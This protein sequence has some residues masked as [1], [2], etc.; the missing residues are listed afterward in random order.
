MSEDDRKAQRDA[1]QAILDEEMMK[2]RERVKAWQA[3]KAKK[4]A[5]EEAEVDH[6]S[7][8]EQMDEDQLLQ[9]NEQEGKKISVESWT[10]DDDEDDDTGVADGDMESETVEEPSGLDALP[11]LTPL[12]D[13]SASLKEEVQVANADD[14]A[15]FSISMSGQNRSAKRHPTIAVS[16]G[17]NSNTSTSTA[18]KPVVPFATPLSISKTQAH[19]AA[20]KHVPSPNIKAPVASVPAAGKR[21]RFAVAKDAQ[22]PSVTDSEQPAME[23]VNTDTSEDFDPLDAYMSDLY[24]GGDVTQQDTTSIALGPSKKKK[25]HVPPNEGNTVSVDDDSDDSDVNP[26]GSNF[27]TLDQIMGQGVLDQVKTSKPISKNKGIVIDRSVS[28]GWESDS[29]MSQYNDDETPAERQAREEQE[30]KDRQEF[31]EAIKKAREQEEAEERRYEEGVKALE[32]KMNTDSMSEDIADANKGRKGNREVELGRVFAGEGDVL[33]DFEIEAKKKSAL[34]LL[35]EQK[36]GKELKPVDHKQIQYIHFRKNLYIV[37]R[38]FSKLSAEEVKMK[39]DLMHVK[40]RGKQCP[41]PVDTWEQCGLSDRVLAVIE[42]NELK[43]PFPIQAQAIPAIMC[44]RDVIGVAKTGSGKTLAF[45][46][47]MLRHILDQPP[48]GEG[49]GPIGLIM[50]P[51]RELAFQIYNEA[52]KFCKS[53]GLRATC[54]YGGAGI[55]EQIAD[56]KRGSDIVVCTPGRM[57]DILCM[58]AGKLVS[59]KRVSFCVMDEADRMFDM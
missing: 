8:I 57:I 20:T 31:I 4:L 45:L 38:I 34:E 43:A 2:R 51:A 29:G 44:G 53:L 40:V 37:P 35:E 27:I 33:D 26:Y 14:D 32:R 12:I 52:R 48:L 11:P 39:R 50:A 47:P 6:R 42:K 15:V 24:G 18:D 17:A 30:E 36:R 58:Q 13:S 3:A 10:L 41:C 7:Q 59:F 5:E 23:V 16:L 28:A 56:L 19:D 55:A 25:T 49:E 9:D 1:E 46:L 21:N 22:I 54:V